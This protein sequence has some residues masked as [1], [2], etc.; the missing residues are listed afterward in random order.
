MEIVRRTCIPRRRPINWGLQPGG[1][2]VGLACVKMR[3]KLKLSRFDDS[4]CQ[5]SIGHMSTKFDLGTCG[6][7]RGGGGRRGEIG[8]ANTGT[9]NFLRN[10]IN[11]FWK[12]YLRRQTDAKM[13]KQTD[14]QRDSE[15]G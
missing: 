5:A 3:V 12:Q 13:C 10:T 9:R 15:E 11:L 1:G 7:G 6:L 2:L 4:V 14:T 8:S